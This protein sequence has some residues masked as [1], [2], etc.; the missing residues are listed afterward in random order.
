MIDESNRED[1][2]ENVGPSPAAKHRE[3]GYHVA[4]VLPCL[5]APS[6][7]KADNQVGNKIALSPYYLPIG[8]LFFSLWKQS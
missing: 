7:K 2:Q 4:W 1:H 3:Q 5:A 8:A 6:V